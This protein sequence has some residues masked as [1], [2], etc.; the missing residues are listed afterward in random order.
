M[1]FRSVTEFAVSVLAML[2]I[3]KPAAMTGDCPLT[4]NL[5]VARSVRLGERPRGRAK[6]KR[7]NHG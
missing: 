6:E 2:G 4:G 7:S 1:G 5:P 3:E